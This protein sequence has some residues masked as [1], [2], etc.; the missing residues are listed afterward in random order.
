MNE[1]E[2]SLGTLFHQITFQVYPCSMVSIYSSSPFSPV[3]EM[4][5]ETIPDQT[6]SRPTG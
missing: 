1:L 2:F 6:G 4:T 3:P 5:P